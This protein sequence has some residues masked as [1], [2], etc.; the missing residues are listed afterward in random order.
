MAAVALPE[1]FAREDAER[2]YLAMRHLG[3]EFDCP[4]VGGDVAG[5]AGPLAVTVTVLARPGPAGC[6]RRN[7]ARPGDAIC[8]TGSLG[9]A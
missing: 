9:G 4:L 6:I 7:G 2:L 8:V 5:T 1:G 3:D